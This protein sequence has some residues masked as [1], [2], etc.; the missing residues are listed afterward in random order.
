MV[1]IMRLLSLNVFR[2]NYINLLTLFL[3]KSSFDV[4]CL[5]EVNFCD[6]EKIEN[7]LKMEGIF[8]PMFSDKT[9]NGICILSKHKIKSHKSFYYYKK[10]RKNKRFPNIDRVLLTAKIGI[11]GVDYDI[12][13]T[14]FTWTKN[15]KADDFQRTDLKELFSI[16]D[17]YPELVLCGDFNIPQGEELYFEF[18]K[19]YKGNVPLTYKSSLDPKLHKAGHLNLVVDHLF[20]SPKYCAK[21]VKL[22]SGV[23]DHKAIVAKIYK[24]KKT[25]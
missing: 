25:A 14:H 11:D 7:A 2:D 22:I 17:N 24:K 5:C 16:L 21:N 19:R 6:L 15:G 13:T 8:F 20:T 12:A 18:I 10:D 1:K 3:K 23:S 9:E 4:V